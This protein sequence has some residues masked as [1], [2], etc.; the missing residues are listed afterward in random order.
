MFQKR[1]VLWAHKRVIANAAR[2]MRSRTDRGLRQ[3]EFLTQPLGRA[4]IGVRLTRAVLRHLHEQVANYRVPVVPSAASCAI[5]G[6]TPQP[7]DLKPQTYTEG[8]NN[9]AINLRGKIAKEQSTSDPGGDASKIQRHDTAFRG[10]S[11]LLLVV[12]DCGPMPAHNPLLRFG[13]LT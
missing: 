8:L 9:Y 11:L 3:L 5:C 2:C 10:P 13:V 6:K 1:N 12:A 4:G 7:A